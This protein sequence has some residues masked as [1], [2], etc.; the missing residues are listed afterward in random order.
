MLALVHLKRACINWVKELSP[1]W[2]KFCLYF[3]DAV[4]QHEDHQA[5]LADAGLA[6]LAITDNELSRRLDDQDDQ[7]QH[8]MKGTAIS[9][10]SSYLFRVDEKNMNKLD[11]QDMELFRHCTA[12]LLFLSKRARPD[13]QMAVA[14]LCTRA[15]EP[16]S[17]DYEKL[18]RVMKYL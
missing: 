7:A 15:H 9:P 12:Q 17:D 3:S 2:D 13:L 14:F 16:D 1:T 11:K 5:A 8:D 6:N 10:A 4:L 18:E